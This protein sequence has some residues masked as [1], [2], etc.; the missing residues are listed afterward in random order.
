MRPL[1]Y[2]EKRRARGLFIYISFPLS[3]RAE[4]FFFIYFFSIFA[5]QCDRLTTLREKNP[6]APDRQSTSE[7]NIYGNSPATRRG[8][9]VFL[10]SA[11]PPLGFFFIFSTCTLHNVPRKYITRIRVFTA[12]VII[13]V[14]QI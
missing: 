4:W 9:A 7:F 8:E 14:R 3:R 12:C 13:G 6:Y 5:A 1:H 10:L 11:L 2:A